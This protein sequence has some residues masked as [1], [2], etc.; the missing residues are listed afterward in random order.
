MLRLL[1]VEADPT[2]APRSDRIRI[3]ILTIFF[4]PNVTLVYHAVS[5]AW[6]SSLEEEEITVDTGDGEEPMTLCR[7]CADVL[8]QLAM[9]SEIGPVLR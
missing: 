9:Q 8:R 1:E 6:G 7:N 3:S 2:N 4:D 5:Y